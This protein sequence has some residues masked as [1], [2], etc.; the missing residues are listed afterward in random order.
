MEIR[1]SA[2]LEQVRSDLVQ[3]RAFHNRSQ[4]LTGMDLDL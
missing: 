1:W 4:H 2:R 3:G